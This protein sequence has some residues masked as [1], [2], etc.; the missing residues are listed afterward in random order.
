MTSRAIQK[1]GCGMEGVVSQVYTTCPKF[2]KVTILHRANY[3][4]TVTRQK[5]E[6]EPFYSV[7]N[8]DNITLKTLSKLTKEMVLCHYSIHVTSHP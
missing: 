1:I 4:H 8:T 7:P 2:P 6:D 3:V 5:L